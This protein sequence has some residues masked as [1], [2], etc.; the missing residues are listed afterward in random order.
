VQLL[1]PRRYGCQRGLGHHRP[2]PARRRSIE[3]LERSATG[4]GP[5]LFQQRR[6]IEGHFGSLSASVFGRPSLPPWVRRLERVPRWVAAK[7][8]IWHCARR[9]R[10]HA[11]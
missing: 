4:L 1:A 11:A 3:L 9:I 2:G 5:L 7:L 6:R 8:S 10:K